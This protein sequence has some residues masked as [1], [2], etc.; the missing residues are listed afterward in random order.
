ME[1]RGQ[2]H[3]RERLTESLRE[4]II[5]ILAGELADPRIGL[6][7]VTDL[8]MGEGGRSMRVFVSV[9]GTEEEAKQTMEGLAAAVGYIRHELGENLGLRKVPDLYFHLD[10]SQKYTERIDTLL[11][12]LQKRT[13]KQ[14]PENE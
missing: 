1:S 8:V 6:V 13:R 12:R 10:K 9:E 3:H 5:T 7:T 11:G 2:K 14:A 4:E